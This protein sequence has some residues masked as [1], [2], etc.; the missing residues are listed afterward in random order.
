MQVGTQEYRKLFGI[1][2]RNPKWHGLHHHAFRRDL[3]LKPDV[4]M[5]ITKDGL[6]NCKWIEIEYVLSARLSVEWRNILCKHLQELRLSDNTLRQ[7]IVKTYSVHHG[8]M[9]FTEN[10][11]PIGNYACR[12]FGCCL[13]HPPLATSRLTDFV[14]HYVT[15]LYKETETGIR[16]EV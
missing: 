11:Y 16:Q 6:T 3:D 10:F 8:F 12:F 13:S 5:I 14:S 4:H 2:S 7:I 9:V 15:F 1:Y